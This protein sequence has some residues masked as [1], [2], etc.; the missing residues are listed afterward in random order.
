MNEIFSC[1]RQS[2]QIN[3]SEY[4]SRP[5]SF[6]NFQKIVNFILQLKG[7]SG[8][9]SEWDFFLCTTKSKKINLS[10]IYNG[11]DPYLKFQILGTFIFKFRGASG[12]QG[13]LRFFFLLE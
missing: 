9:R 2:F 3:L 4:H 6:L 13:W 8:H 7:C 11:L 1:A 12:N 10:E 5:D